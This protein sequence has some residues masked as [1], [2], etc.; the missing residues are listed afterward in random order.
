MFENYMLLRCCH[1]IGTLLKT[2]INDNIHT[3]LM[4]R[5]VKLVPNVEIHPNYIHA[6][7]SQR[8]GN[9]EK[10]C[11]FQITKLEEHNKNQKF[12]S[13]SQIKWSA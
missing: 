9:N 5:C 12:N 7:L 10:L 6:M 8:G 1:N 11:N 3:K 4:Q 2:T 13:H